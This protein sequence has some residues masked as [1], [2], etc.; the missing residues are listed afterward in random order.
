MV[1][2][3][4]MKDLAVFV[5]QGVGKSGGSMAVGTVDVTR[6]QPNENQLFTMSTRLSYPF[7][8]IH[9]M[10]FSLGKSAR[11]ISLNRCML[12]LSKQFTD[13]L[14][15]NER[16]VFLFFRPSILSFTMHAS[17]CRPTPCP[18]FPSLENTACGA[19][20]VPNTEG[21][22]R[23]IRSAVGAAKREFWFYW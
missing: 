10:A 9:I 22:K 23:N 15:N 12:K 19:S 4:W 1:E 16:H 11:F 17:C 3:G 7:V 20:F 13:P 8:P 6:S 2:S 14:G 5:R 18:V 21:D